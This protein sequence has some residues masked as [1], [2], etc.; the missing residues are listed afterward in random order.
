MQNAIKNLASKGVIKGTTEEEFSPEKPITRAEVAA[1]IVRIL[2]IDDPNADGG[3][4]D[5]ERADWFYG[6]AGVSKHQGIIVGYEDNTFRGK[7]VIPKVQITS[8]VSRTLKN[9]CGYNDISTSN[10]GDYSDLSNIPDWA[11]NDIALTTELNM[12]IKRTDASFEPNIEMTRGDAAVII[13]KLY[14]KVW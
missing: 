3:F 11:K 2:N 6:T 10:L 9:N 12:I 13:E 5:V 8:V 4:V 7:T 14:E 1:L